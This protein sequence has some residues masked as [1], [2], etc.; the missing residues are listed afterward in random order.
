MT[1]LKKQAPRSMYSGWL[2]NYL[3]KNGVT[4]SHVSEIDDLKVERFFES[5]DLMPLDI[6]LKLFEWAARHFDRPHLGL[7][8]ASESTIDDFGLFG[9]LT[10]S[11]ETIRELCEQSECYQRILMQGAALEFVPQGNLIEVRYSIVSGLSDHLIQDVEF[12]LAIMVKIF[13]QSHH[14]D[15][16]PSRTSFCHKA[17]DPLSDYTDVFGE[18]I[19]FEQAS[20][21]LWFE[22]KHW[23]IPVVTA[24]PTLHNVLAEQANR[25]LQEIEGKTDF[26]GS[27]KFRI[28]SRLGDESFNIESLAQELNMSSRTLHRKLRQENTT[29]KDVKIDLMMDVAKHVLLNEP[30]SIAEL[31]QTLGYSESSA[32]VR[33]FKRV[34]G[35]SPLQYRK[36][37]IKP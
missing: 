22:S 9:F 35:Q 33:V 29:F 13:Q 4:P 27:V 8:I 15:W 7:D 2:V 5:P 14:N 31:A 36:Q 30:V 17:L 19:D 20:N 3:K 37:H 23:D 34:Q 28:S 21:S 18:N 32:F 26:L 1:A 12:S 25:L 16:R 24:N 11:T 6:Y 10:S